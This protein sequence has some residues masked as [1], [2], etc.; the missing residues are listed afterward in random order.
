MD[1]KMMNRG[2]IVTAA[3][4]GINLALGVLYA[5]SIF[6]GAIRDSIEHGTGFT[7]DLASLNDP[8]AICCLVFSFV[9]IAAGRVQDLIGPRTAAIIGGVLVGLG[10]IWI[11]QTTAYWSWVMGFGVLI[12]A[13]IAFGYSAATPAALKW[14]PPKRTGMISGI[15]VSGF[16]LASVYIAPLAKYLLDGWGLQKAM[17]FFGIGFFLV[18][19]ALAT[20]L[21]NPPRGYVPGGRPA[22]GTE[23]AH[24]TE[25]AETD[26]SAGMMIRSRDFWVLWT[27][28]FIGAGAGLMV[29][30]SMAGMA[31]NSMGDKA[32][33]AVA[34]LAIGNAGGRI[35]AGIL[36]DRIGRKQT[37]IAIF[38]GQAVLMFMAAP[39]IIYGG[40]SATLLVLIATSIG[41]NYGANLALFPSFTKNLWGMKNFG[42]NYGV[43]FTAWG[44]GGLV[45][46]KFS[47]WLFARTG[48]FTDSLLLAGVL[49]V[50]SVMLT[51]LIRDQR[52]SG[53]EGTTAA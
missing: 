36:S 43:L 47:Q 49:L 38:V 27:L 33:W 23:G 8:Y 5:W 9:M 16:G 40:Q 46:S 14:F 4:T 11:S 7:W 24:R 39:I 12:G 13:G 18:V 19:S 20:L 15:V 48:A 45:M 25:K 6:K 22:P 10:F 42:V 28:Y 17:L 44:V 26:I 37:L 35:A 2:P 32:F 50:A 41:F 30:G 52:H 1:K 31:K 53:T 34:I 51:P 3:G 21:K 29:I